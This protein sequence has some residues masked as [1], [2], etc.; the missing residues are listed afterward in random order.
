MSTFLLT[1]NPLR[2]PWAHLPRLLRLSSTGKSVHQRWS[3]GNNKSIQLGDRVFLLRQGTDHPGL[4]AS[5]WVTKGSYLDDPWD[6]NVRRKKSLY[7]QADW[8]PIVP[9]E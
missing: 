4:I 3:C 1:W 9:L 8:S 5:G 6:E 2:Y 7:V